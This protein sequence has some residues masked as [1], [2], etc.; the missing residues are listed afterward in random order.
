M[1]KRLYKTMDNKEGNIGDVPK[2]L[3]LS[4][5][6][7]LKVEKYKDVCFYDAFGGNY[8]TKTC[9][10]EAKSFFTNAT[11]NMKKSVYYHLLLKAS[12]DGLLNHYPGSTK[13]ARDVFS[14]GRFGN[15]K[16]IYNSYEIMDVILCFNESQKDINEVPLEFCCCNAYH[17]I[18][19]Y[20][21]EIE[22]YTSGIVMLDPFY[23]EWEK[24]MNGCKRIIDHLKDIL[25]NKLSWSIIMWIP[26]HTKD[27]YHQAIHLKK[28][29]LQLGYDSSLLSIM[30]PNFEGLQSIKGIG[31]LLLNT[32]KELIDKIERYDIHALGQMMDRQEVQ[33]FINK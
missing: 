17:L 32:E 30:D 15:C 31:L 16:V 21:H 5:L 22:K 10:R 18:D 27:C 26:Y 6:L 1:L 29:C 9:Q 7:Q 12:N 25:K 11:E 20:K 3:I 23:T 14:Q 33:Y 8:I 24:D 28:E 19:D 13:L 2:H 4:E